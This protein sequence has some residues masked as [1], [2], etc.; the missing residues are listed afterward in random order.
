MY[1]AWACDAIDFFY[2]F[3]AELHPAAGALGTYA[4]TSIMVLHHPRAHA[5][6]LLVDAGAHL[7][8]DP[9]GLMAGDRGSAGKRE[10]KRCRSTF[11]TVEFQIAA[12]HA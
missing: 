12:A 4:T 5:R 11:G 6:L 10:P 8:H 3:D 9:A 7:G 2:A 1:L